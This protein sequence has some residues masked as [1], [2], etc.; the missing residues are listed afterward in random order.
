MLTLTSGASSLVVAPEHG[1]GLTGWMLG[2]TPLLRRAL[3]QASAG[4][5]PHAMACFPLL[6]YGNRL[7]GSQ[8][9]W[10]GTDYRL[11][12]NIGDNPHAIHGVGWQRAW[13]VAEVGPGSATL[14]LD[15][16]PDECWPFAFDASICYAL[17]GSALTV[18]I[19]ITS[20]HS[21][22][23][24]AGIGLHPFFPKMHDPALRFDATGVWENGHDALP[25]RHCRPQPDRAH[26]EPRLIARSRLDNCFTEWNGTADI[27]AGP[28]SLRIEASEAFR[29]LQVFTPSW[30]DFFC[31]EPVSHCPDA[32]NRP[33][34]PE[35]QA[36]HVLEPDET[37]SGT[38][39][40]CPIEA[41]EALQPRM[42]AD[43]RA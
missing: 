13:T 35:R 16:T 6:P 31:V 14:T 23:S 36:M 18:T 26:T 2:S 11:K 3:P 40:L 4:G 12:L 33:G 29:Q 27:L 39:R 34:L 25:A 10:L 43:T 20:R 1:A 19:Q 28:A 41:S 8:F 22:L 30:T 9:H 38:V 5:D 37:L 21:A 42:H 17:S 7:G 24:P 15:H 32:I